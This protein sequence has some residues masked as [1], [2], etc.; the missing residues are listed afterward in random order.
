MQAT[1]TFQINAIRVI[2]SNYFPWLI[3]G[4]ENKKPKDNY[5]SAII[6]SDDIIVRM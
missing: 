3:N 4:K 6:I 5:T 2:H 1:V